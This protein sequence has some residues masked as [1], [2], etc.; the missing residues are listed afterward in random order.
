[1][2]L[3]A[4]KRLQAEGLRLDEIERRFEDATDGQLAE[5]AQLSSNWSGTPPVGPA[6]RE[7]LEVKLADTVT[8]RLD[9]I[10]Q[11]PAHDRR[12]IL[13]AAQPLL[14]ELARQKRRR[15]RLQRKRVSHDGEE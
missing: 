3:V 13:R 14:H 2:Q 8:L 4:I 9:A 6:Q 5:W 12:R 10:E 7:P 11:L 15:L 1:M